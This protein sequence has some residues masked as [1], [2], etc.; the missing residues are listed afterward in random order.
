L[1]AL[2]VLKKKGWKITSDAV[3]SGMSGVQFSGRF[4]I[5]NF[6][7]LIVIDGGHNIEG[8]TSFV[9]NFKKYFPGKKANLFFGMLRDKQV[10]A[11]LALL[12]QIAKRIYTLTPEDPRA[13][14]AEEMTDYVKTHYKNIGSIPLARMDDIG[15]YVDFSAA[16]EIYAFTGSL[17]MIGHARTELNRLISQ[18]ASE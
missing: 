6:S 14:A 17:Y 15:Q 7:P 13:V 16:Q 1:T 18:N 4:E 3:M 10:D 8:I 5:L 2:E 9:E 12:T 11:S